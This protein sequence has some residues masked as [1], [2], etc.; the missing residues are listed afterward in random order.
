MRVQSVQR[1]D[2]GLSY[3]P[4]CVA[5]MQ[6]AAIEAV[7]ETTAPVEAAEEAALPV[8]SDPPEEPRREHTAEPVAQVETPVAPT[9]PEG[10]SV[11]STTSTEA[12]PAPA[13]IVAAAPPEPQQESNGH[14]QPQPDRRTAIVGAGASDVLHQ[15]LRQERAA[16]LE[17]REALEEE[18]REVERGMQAIGRRLDHVQ[19]LLDEPV[20][21]DGGTGKE[22]GAA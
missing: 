11:T 12:A 17:H 8:T 4:K 16:L 22:A 9:A 2:D 6:G 21:M 13:A 19:A 3:C 10:G 1:L 20:M 5:R 15:A 18:L 7:D 14:A